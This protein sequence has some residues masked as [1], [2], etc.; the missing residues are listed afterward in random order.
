MRGRNPRRDWLTHIYME[1]GHWNGDGWLLTGSRHCVLFSTADA[2]NLENCLRKI[3][4]ARSE[5]WKLL[6]LVP[7]VCG[8]FVCVWNIS[9]NCW[10]DFHHIH[11][12][13]VFGP[14]LDEFDGQGQRSKSP[15]T[16]TAFFGPFGSLW[17]FVFG[18]TSLASSF[19]CCRF[20][21][22][23]IQWLCWCWQY[24]LF[25]GF[26]WVCHLKSKFSSSC[27]C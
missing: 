24:S 12:E 15:G 17:R 3:I 27:S 16:K 13:D 26:A 2:D 4:T 18:K 10:T 22:C 1:S 19:V 23:R 9:R 8:F 14:H 6:F 11:T 21:R 5:L 25:A 20:L 7:L